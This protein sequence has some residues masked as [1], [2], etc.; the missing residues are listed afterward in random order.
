LDSI[1]VAAAPYKRCGALELDVGSAVGWRAYR[2]A[3]AR[4]WYGR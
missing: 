1:Q 4:Y 3:H 2:A